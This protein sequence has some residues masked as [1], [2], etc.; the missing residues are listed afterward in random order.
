MFRQFYYLMFLTF[1]MFSVKAQEISG[2]VL[3]DKNEELIGATIQIKD[4]EIG[5]VTN[6]NGDFSIKHDLNQPITLVI[7]SIGFQVKELV[8]KPLSQNLSINLSPNDLGL[9]AI[10]ITGTMTPTMV[11]NSPVKI[12][13]ITSKHIN[14]YLPSAASSLIDGIKMINGVQEVVACGVC[15]TNNI[16]INGLPGPYT[17][18]LIDGS[19]VYGNLASVYG[20]NGIPSMIVD[21]FEVIKGPNSTL[22]GSEAMAGVINV[23]TKKPEDQPALSIDIMATSHLES[24]GNVASA[25]SKDAVS[26][27]VGFNYAIIDGFDDSNNDG[28]GDRINL[29]RYT[30]FSKTVFKRKNDL[31]F[32]LASKWLYEDRRNGVE[33]YLVDHAYKSIRGN[34]SIYGESIN[35]YRGEFFGTL[36]LLEDQKLKLDY[37]LSHH[38]QNSYYGSDF[39]KANQSIGFFNLIGTRSIA[40]HQLTYGLTQRLQ[41]YDDNTVATANFSADS[42]VSNRP[43]FQYI[44]GVFGQDEWNIYRSLTLLTGLR[45]DHYSRHG[46]I[47]SPRVSGKFKIGNW[48]TFRANFGTGFRIVNLFTEDHAFLTGQREVIIEEEL[49]PERSINLSLNFNQVFTLGNSQ[50][51][52]DIDAFYSRFTNKIIPDYSVPDK[53]IYA[54][55]AGHA[56]S[57]G[58]GVNVTQEFSKGF[59]YTAGFNFQRVYEYENGEEVPVEFAPNFSA[60]A[61]INY[62]LTNP[63]LSIAYSMRLTGS[64]Q[65][66][67]VFDII[68]NGDRKAESRPTRSSPFSFHNIQITWQKNRRWTVYGGVQ[69]IFNFK[70]NESPLVG[71]NDPN[72]P[73]GFSE[74]FDTSYSYAPIHGRE[75]YVGIKWN[76]PKKNNR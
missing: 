72:A 10:V 30:L 67:E 33:D 59:N 27:F 16:S 34:D 56:I 23:I 53:I 52:L 4:T 8:V 54:N 40:K 18:V 49:N 74:S 43:D 5:A 35:T 45:I 71:F 44:P 41:Y 1:S 48:S 29:N 3:S 57:K 46:I 20:L 31:R 55:V 28:F 58:I 14:N 42:L 11:K 36:D 17:S 51:M 21:R 25:F 47:P 6:L 63:S 39:Y 76:L 24:F 65:L 2:K 7:R 15:F 26:G 37:S 66:P 19:P 22:Y 69:N 38:N 75:L 73:V 60:L 68:H 61:N 50:G 70:Q 64:M 12:E 62:V 9:D 32:T 13:V